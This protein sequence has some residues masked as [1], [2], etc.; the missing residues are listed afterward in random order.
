MNIDEIIVENINRLMVER[1]LSQVKLA[2]N[3]KINVQNLNRLLRLKR[4]IVK[5]DVLPA[6]ARE[7]GVTVNDL[8]ARP[9]EV[10]YKQ[11]SLALAEEFAKSV[12]EK[13]KRRLEFLA[14]ELN[15]DESNPEDLKK[16][17]ALLP[18]FPHLRK[19]PVDILM[20]LADQDEKYFASLRKV[21]Q[22]L[23]E[24]KYGT[25]EKEKKKS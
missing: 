1:G 10:E 18:V 2:Q 17:E 8:M 25:E 7:L 22:G 11:R 21:L 20:L 15:L 12:T 5:S 24:K 14:W 6:I 9:D 19:I 4:S 16:M 23:Y 3:A 13:R